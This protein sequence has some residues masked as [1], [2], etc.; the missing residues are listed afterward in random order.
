MKQM[1]N[2]MFLLTVFLLKVQYPG[3]IK[4]V[5]VSIH[6]KDQQQFYCTVFYT[7]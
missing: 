6:K 7:H 5:L 2:N 3:F 4:A 1:N